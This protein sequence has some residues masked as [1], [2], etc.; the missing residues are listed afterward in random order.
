MN[1]DAENEP[2]YGKYQGVVT[3]NRDPE[4]RGRIKARVPDV[5]GDDE[6]GWALPCA[7]FSGFCALPKVGAGVWIEF[8]GGDPD[9]PIWC[10]CWWGSASEM[11][12]VLLP[13]PDQKVVLQTEG[14]NRITFDDLPGAGGI[15]LETSGGQK[16]KLTATAIE[17]DNGHGATIK[18]SGPTVQINDQALEVT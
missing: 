3:D 18:M 16:I 5:Y 6:S 4:T 10:G 15:I 7:P 11:P 12:T 17:I 14:G 1:D 8:E 9:Y 2:F 13:S